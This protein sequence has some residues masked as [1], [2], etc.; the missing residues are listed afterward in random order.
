VPDTEVA[1]LKPASISPMSLL[2]D[3]ASSTGH[4]KN[5]QTVAKMVLVQAPL[6]LPVDVGLSYEIETLQAKT[7]EQGGYYNARLM[8]KYIE[9]IS[10]GNNFGM[11]VEA[12][13][14]LEKKSV[15]QSFDNELA[16]FSAAQTAAE[17]SNQ[18]SM[19]NQR[20]E[21]LANL[22]QM[23]RAEL[24]SGAEEMTVAI[25]KALEQLSETAKT[26]T[27][28]I[29]ELNAK[30]A[31]CVDEIVEGGT[32]FGEGLN[33]LFV[34]VLTT[35]TE[36]KADVDPKAVTDDKD[37]SKD[38]KSAG[39]K[40]DENKTDD[41]KSKAASGTFVI[42]SI[43][44]SS[45]G[46]G[47]MGQARADLMKYNTQLAAAYQDLASVNCAIT[48]AKVAEVQNDQFAAVMG[49]LQECT[50]KISTTWGV[51]PITPP[52]HGISLQFA[53]F[54]DRIK[55]VKS[56]EEANQLSQLMTNQLISWQEFNEQMR[57]TRATLVGN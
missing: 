27:A 56:K 3:Y 2:I 46:I 37:K 43:T 17:L 40:L 32:K 57:F 12:F 13:I 41:E 26:E 22:T 45:E 38:K 7:K 6:Q 30:I 10:L 9:L 23:T 21:S 29:D 28:K 49:K 51:S 25:K 47:Q 44:T 11:L 31:K 53:D 55:S 42:K 39:K 8:P 14:S 4:F 54:S 16:R 19:I 50:K 24:S 35:I 36:A 15:E 18:A 48:L 20:A 1:S 34:G 52:G 33:D 5:G